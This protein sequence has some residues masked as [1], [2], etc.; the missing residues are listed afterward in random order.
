MPEFNS[1]GC[2]MIM[3][4]TGL[5]F[6][7]RHHR[8]ILLSLLFFIIPQLLIGAIVEETGSLRGFLAGYCP[9][10]AYDNWVSHVSEGI[11]SPGYNNYG[12]EDLDIQ[13][14]G[15]GEYRIIP[16]TPAGDAILEDWRIIFN[17]FIRGQLNL[18][19]MRLADSSDSYYYDVVLFHDLEY[20]K[21]YYILRERLDETYVDDSGTPDNTDDDVIGSFRN[22]WG[23]FVVNP[24]AA[25]PNVIIQMVHPNDDFLGVQASVQ[26]FFQIDCGFLAISGAGREVKWTEEGDYSN[27]KS[28]S[29]VSRTGRAPLQVFQEV[30]R[31]SLESNYPKGPLFIQY[32]SYDHTHEDPKSI[33]VSAGQTETFIHKPFRDR[34]A[35][36]HD[37]IHLTPEI[38]VEQN[39]LG[40]HNAVSIE[41]YYWVNYSQFEPFYYHY[42]E[43]DSILL[44]AADYLRCDPNNQQENALH[45][46]EYVSGAMFE[47]FLHIE[48][49]EYPVALQEG[50]IAWLDLFG[51]ERPPTHV[52]FEPMLRYYDSFH[53][54]LVDYFEILNSEREIDPPETVTSVEVISTTH[55]GFTLTWDTIFNSYFGTY[56]VV[57]DTIPLTDESPVIWDFHNDPNLMDMEFGGQTVVT[58]L[59]DGA[60]WNV[61]VRGVDYY[62]Q[63]GE[64]SPVTQVDFE[65]TESII[66][67]PR[68]F[69]EFPSEAWPAWVVV[70]VEN[71]D[72]LDSLW[73]E[74]NT[75]GGYE[76]IDRLEPLKD[77]TVWGT[78]LGLGI[79]SVDAGNLIS[80]S[81]HASDL[82]AMGNQVRYPPVNWYQFTLNDDDPYPHFYDFEDDDADLYNTGDW[83]WGIPTS[84]PDSAYSGERLWATNLHGDYS[85]QAFGYLRLDDINLGGYGP[86][87]FTWRH[88]IDYE[89]DVNMMGR[90]YD[91]GLI[92]VRPEGDTYY[93]VAPVG[94]YPYVIISGTNPVDESEAYSGQSGGWKTG[95]VNLQEWA[96]LELSWVG[97]VH[98]SDV[99]VAEDGWFVDD[100]AVLPRANSYPPQPFALLFPDDDIDINP[101]NEI[102]FTWYSSEDP[103][104]FTFP[105][106]HLIMALGN[107]TVTVY[108]G[109]DTSTVLRIDTLA[110]ATEIPAYID[111]WV[112][113]VS[114]DDYVESYNKWRLAVP[115]FNSVNE[116][117]DGL[118]VKFALEAGYPNPFNPSV[119]LRFAIPLRS[120]TEIEIFNVLGQMVDVVDRR[121]RDIGYHTINWNASNFASGV[122]LVSMK[123]GNFRATRKVVLVK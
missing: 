39:I 78:S 38:P 99:S 19:D 85:H 61:A 83:E 25:L 53:Q 20:N 87:M 119:N 108:T 8:V 74:W 98:S 31:D 111:W 33:V 21:D 122:Y 94:G 80:Y 43:G 58:G 42:S 101:G 15:F 120:F 79:D 46:D 64:L 75:D 28:L 104:P 60:T 14:D 24:E 82:S 91:G 1:V 5:L 88:W 106:Y 2:R 115:P 17:S 68:L 29:D 32:H 84:G 13:T 35:E 12:P 76:G 113:A 7:R 52:T 6:T 71:P 107:D 4:S 72:D 45:D 114:Q 16:D 30:L 123:S 112:V 95:A 41:D 93:Q 47:N 55:D 110:L 73:I 103:D 3:N 49:D 44:S 57:A 69:N 70:E 56:E 121:V 63:R 51:D 109:M 11:A 18:T 92:R 10:A 22:G 37:F 48:I 116:N 97:F 65:D 96:G 9:T 77:N 90:A 40:L 27:S 26:L 89:E 67:F 118:P 66:L 100:I 117:E 34:S 23:V 54:S 105:E 59:Q 81:V 102:L 86:M 36:H 50:G 62:G